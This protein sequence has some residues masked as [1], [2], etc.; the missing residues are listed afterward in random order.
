M[1]DITYKI[2]SIDEANDD[3][4]VTITK[5][6]KVVDATIHGLP[7]GSK[8]EFEQALKDYFR[9]YQIGDRLSKK[10]HKSVTDLVGTNQTVAED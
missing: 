8:K 4:K 7:T 3:V 1:A 10:A 2:V 6:A 9:A 5:G